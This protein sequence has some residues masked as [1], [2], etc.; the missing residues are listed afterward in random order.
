MEIIQDEIMLWEE[1]KKHFPNE[2]VV[3]GNPVFEDMKILQ[4]TVLAHHTDKR[5][6]SLEGGERRD[7]FNKFTLVFTGQ[8]P[9]KHHI[10]LLRKIPKSLI[11]L[12]MVSFPTIQVF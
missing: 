6:T 11:L 10:G 7:G 2:W 5:V 12:P 4:G 8:L 9:P 3:L 1:I